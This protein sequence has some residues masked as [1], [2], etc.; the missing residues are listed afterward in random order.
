MDAIFFLLLFVVIGPFVSSIIYFFRFL[1]VE[2]ESK[3]I[4]FII[5]EFWSILVFPLYFLIAF[6]LGKV[7]DCCGDNAVFSPDHRLVIYVL[8]FLYMLAYIISM[9]RK[10]QFPPLLELLLNLFLIIGLVLNVILCFHLNGDEFGVIFWLPGNIPVILLITIKLIK[11]HKMILVEVDENA[12]VSNSFTD[13]VSLWILRLN[14]F[15]KYPVLLV[16]L[17]PVVVLLSLCLL[18]FGQKPDSVIRAFTDTYK[19]GFSQLD[20]QCANVECGGHFLCSVGANG[21]KTIV[22]PE[23]YGERNGGK[24][25]CTR[26]LLI[27]NAFEELLQEN[28]PSAHRFIRHKYNTVGNFI[29]RY[30]YV[31]NIKVVSDVVYILM[32]PLEWC[33]LLFLYSFDSK[34]E[35]RIARQ[36]L[37]KQDQYQIQQTLKISSRV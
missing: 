12:V 18:V 20:Y 14:P 9:F 23:R 11:N 28:F 22:K 13:Y 33:F 1:I 29:H 6:D 2:E 27:S 32:K 34:P 37:S 16:L 3:S 15:L 8:I 31:F 21:H 17:V 7:N 10:S 4:F 25:I 19:H 36:Y 5:T 24:I 35:N 26:Q 30:Y